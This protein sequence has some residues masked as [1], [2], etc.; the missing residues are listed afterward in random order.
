YSKRLA[1][2]I[3]AGRR[4]PLKLVIIGVGK[5]VS[6]YQMREL[7]DLDT[8]TDV[9]LWDHKL[10]PEMRVLEEIFA[11]V[12]DRNARV[13]NNSRILTPD[14]RLVRDYADGGLPAYLEFEV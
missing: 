6:E 10:A 7:D 1:Q 4:N 14:G 8:G 13:A 2:D 3:Q 5:D 9:D 12:V 11:E